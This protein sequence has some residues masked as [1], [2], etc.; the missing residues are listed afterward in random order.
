MIRAK[1]DQSKGGEGRGCSAL[2]SADPNDEL[3]LTSLPLDSGDSDR[4]V[5]PSDLE[6]L[7]SGASGKDCTTE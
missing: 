5:H 1:L 7:R 4:G 6:P 2:S 3:P